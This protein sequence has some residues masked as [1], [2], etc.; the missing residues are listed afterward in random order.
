MVIN[1]A[2]V[3]ISFQITKN[4]NFRQ[5]SWSILERRGHIERLS[6]SSDFSNILI[7]ICEQS[8]LG[9]ISFLVRM[10]DVNV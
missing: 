9:C 6:K 8:R 10:E 5:G 4:L 2:G 1:N 3:E 7:E